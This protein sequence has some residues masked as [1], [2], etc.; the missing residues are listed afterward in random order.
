MKVK[1]LKLTDIEIKLE[2]E[3]E[4]HT[5]LGALQDVFIEDSRV[6]FT[7]YNIPHPLIP[8][9]TFT[10]RVSSGNTVDHVLKSG[11]ENLKE[12]LRGLKAMLESQGAEP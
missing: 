5:F 2:L 1:V 11:V 12:R 10:L 4:D 8:K 6:E 7:G 9:A 3:G